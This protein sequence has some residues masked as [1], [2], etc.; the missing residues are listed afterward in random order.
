MLQPQS[1]GR[2]MVYLDSAATTQQPQAVLDAVQAFT[3]RFN[4][5]VHR[6]TYRAA[7]QATEAFEAARTDVQH[8]LHAARP[9]EIVFTSGATQAINLVAQSL[10]L[11]SHTTDCD[12]KN[13]A[14]GVLRRLR[15]G[16]EVLLSVAEHHSNLLPWQLL[17]ARRGLRLRFLPLDTQRQGVDAQAA[18]LREM[19]SPRTRLVALAQVS[20]VLG[21]GALPVK[22]IVQAA[23]R[24]GALVLLDACQSAGHMPIDVQALGVDFLVASGHKMLAPTGVGVL[25]GRYGLLAALPPAAGGGGAMVERVFLRHAQFAPPPARFESGT[26]PIAA[27]IGLGA[28]CRFLAAQDMLCVQR[29]DESLG[30]Y[31][32]RELVAAVEGVTLYGPQALTSEG[33]LEERERVASTGL[34]SFNIRGVHGLDV[35]LLLDQQGVCVR[36]G[37]HCAQP[38]HRVLGAEGSLRASLALYNNKQDVDIFV[39]AVRDAVD[40]LRATK[41]PPLLQVSQPVPLELS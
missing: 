3:T 12:W 41:R 19:L 32:R 39:A 2:A 23:H 36:S 11:V 8:F 4:A 7:M 15:A 13:G 6:G 20:N 38:L 28:A 10:A 1:D 16:D 35:A 22:E 29:H 21:T 24:V 31:L 34:V 30:R 37:H 40:L 17:A 26:P 25:Y 9:E 33:S 27:A 5:N 14:G 18:R